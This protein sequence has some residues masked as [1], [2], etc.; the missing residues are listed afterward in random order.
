MGEGAGAPFPPGAF[1][2]NL[3]TEGLVDND[4]SVGDRFRTG[5]AELVVTQPRLPCFKLGI[6][7]GRDES[8]EFLGLG[9]TGLLLCRRPRRRSRAPRINRRAPARPARLSRHRDRTPLCAR[10]QRRRR[11]ATCRRT[12]RASGELARLLPQAS[13]LCGRMTPHESGTHGWELVT[14]TPSRLPNRKGRRE[15]ANETTVQDHVARSG[16]QLLDVR[17]EAPHRVNQYDAPP[18]RP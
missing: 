11:D 7:M 14:P 5:T 8:L 1:G 2:E 13:R 3:T 10:P 9:A 15:K 12:R 17:G 16:G 4:V 6:K 18:T